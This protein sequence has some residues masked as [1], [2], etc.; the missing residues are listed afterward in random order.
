[1]ESVDFKVGLYSY[2]DKTFVNAK[3]LAAVL[4]ELEARFVAESE[5][6]AATVCHELKGWLLAQ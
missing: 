4:S 2:E 3:D 5:L 1:M 6:A